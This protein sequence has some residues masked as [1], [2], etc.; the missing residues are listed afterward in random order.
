MISR[1]DFIF[2][3][4]YDGSTAVVD[5]KARKEYGKLGTMQLAEKGLYRAAYSS[6]LYSG[7]ESEMRSFIAYFNGVAGTGYTGSDQLARLFGVSR[8]TITK[9]LLV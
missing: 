2:T 6:A 9:V 4:G 5:G 7:D 3:I 1:E 8:E